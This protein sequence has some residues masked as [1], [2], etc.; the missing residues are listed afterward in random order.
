M[1]GG[2]KLKG[3]E[4]KS[5]GGGRR[6]EKYKTDEGRKTKAGRGRDRWWW[7]CAGVGEMKRKTYKTQ[8]CT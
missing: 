4:Y 1:G 2:W 8:A 5:V 7:W 6:G 3:E